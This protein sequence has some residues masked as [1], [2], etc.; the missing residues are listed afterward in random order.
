MTHPPAIGN[1]ARVTPPNWPA[2]PLSADPA[3]SPAPTGPRDVETYVMALAALGAAIVTLVFDSHSPLT[4]ALLAIALV[5]WA[6]V[7]AA[8]PLPLL[9]FA[10]GTMIPAAAIIITTGGGGPVFF[11]M[12]AVTRVA[13]LTAGRGPI[14][15]AFAAAA[16]LPILFELSNP[17]G[18][19]GP[20]VA[21]LMLGVAGSGLLGVLLYRQH[22]LT[23]ELEWSHRRL[24]EAA[25]ADERR[26]I[27]RDLHDVL[28]HSLT[29]VVVNVAGARRALGS[30]PDL[31]VEA[32][33]R[34]EQ[35]GRDSL[36]GVRRIVGLLRPAEG[37]GSGDGSLARAADLRTIVA[38]HLDAGADVT[39]D[40][41]GGLDGIAPLTS[42]ALARVVQEALTNAGRHAPEAPISV[43]VEV[44]TDRVVLQVTNGPARRP[45]LDRDRHRD[46]LGLI[47][48]RERVEALGGTFSAGPG[49]GGGWQV[50]CAVPCSR[51]PVPA[52]QQG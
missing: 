29:V 10:A 8:V 27:A 1:V 33:S 12:F 25:A 30:R 6:L 43:R 35:T 16:T 45:P 15:A 37:P 44:D 19:T 17:A 52:E 7:A 3:A 49:R 40:V 20:G 4:V 51:S 34:A 14:I 48:M 24:R 26:R 47:G 11:G 5:P 46:G 28:A 21:Y 9:A 39:L 42:F 38:T 13:S 2:P 32:L 18:A 41:R 22:R 23:A 50:T 31:A 36:D